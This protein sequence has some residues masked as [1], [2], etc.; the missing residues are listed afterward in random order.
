MDWT[1]QKYNSYYESYM[2]WI[3]DKYLQW[4]GENKTSYVAK[5][6]LK[7]TKVTGDK[8]VDAAQDGVAEGVGGQFGKGGLGEGV[9]KLTSKEGFSRSER[10]GKNDKGDV[11]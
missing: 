4:F 7:K 9:G 10:G 2:P 1:K 11:I 8:N 5:D 3:E 6:N